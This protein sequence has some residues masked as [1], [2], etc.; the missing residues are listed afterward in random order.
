MQNLRWKLITILVVLVGLASVGVY[1]LVAAW[2]GVHKPALLMDKQLKLGLDLKGGV[3]LELRV[4]T[5]DALRLETE[6][7]MERLREELAKRTIPTTNITSPDSTHF[8]V[9]GVPQTQDAAFRQAV[10]DQN[11]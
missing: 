9:E 10:T 5:D 2:R 6:M 4:N 3:H 11:V 8:R 1:P 7:E